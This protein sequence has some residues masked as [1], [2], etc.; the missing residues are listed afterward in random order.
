[1]S[2]FIDREICGYCGACISVC[3]SNAIE[4]VDA[5][6]RFKTQD[7]RHKT[8][9]IRQETS[10]RR[11]QTGDGRSQVS[12]LESSSCTSCLACVKVCPLGAISVLDAQCLMIDAVDFHNRKS[13][14][15]NRK[16]QMGNRK[17]EIP[18]LSLPS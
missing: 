12:S 10:D 18:P 14:I 5:Y 8:Q 6:V 15:G 7:T 13:E 2:P 3:P 16:S 17:C 1:M 9:G 4:L 11:H